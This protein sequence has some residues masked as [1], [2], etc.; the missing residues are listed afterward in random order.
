LPVDGEYQ[1]ASPMRVFGNR[2]PSLKSLVRQG[3]VDGLIKA[4][5][6]TELVTGPDGRVLDVGAATREKALVALHELAPANAG[7]IFVEALADSS[8]RVR[9]VA[10]MA[11]YER[12]DSDQLANAVVRLPAD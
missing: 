8:D 7:D 11:L 2:K 6:Y 1:P 10:T 3:D 12:G 4:A 5:A 9:C